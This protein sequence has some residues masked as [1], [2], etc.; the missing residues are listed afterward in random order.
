MPIRSVAP[1]GRSRVLVSRARSAAG[2]LPVVLE[3]DLDRGLLEDPPAGAM[4]A[5]R[6]W[7]SPR[8][9]S[10]VDGLRAASGDSE[11][12]GLIV[13]VGAH[14]PGFAVVQ[15]LRNAVA[16]FAASGRPTVCFAESFGELSQS[17]AGYLLA[18]ACDTIFLQP[19]G[20]VAIGG[21]SASAVYLRDALDRLGVQ[22]EMDRRHEFKSAA[23]TFVSRDM[24]EPNR[25]MLAQVVSSLADH[26]LGAVGAGRGLDPAAVARAVA[27]SPVPA[28]R[29]LEFGLVDRLGYA[30]D[31]YADVRDRAGCASTRFVERHHQRGTAPR[32]L[33]SRTVAVVPVTGAIVAGSGVPGRGRNQAT[34]GSVTAALRAARS[35]RAAAV[36]LRVNSPGGSY[37][38]SDAIRHQVHRLRADG[39]PVVAAMGSVAASGG[40]FVSM[41]ADEIVAAPGSVTG[42]IGVLGGKGVVRDLLAKGGVVA[43]TLGSH[44]HADMMSPLRGFSDEEWDKLQAFLDAVY[45]DFTAKAAEDRDM[46]VA[47]LE[48]HARGRVWTGV[49]AVKLGLVDRLGDLRDAVR[50]AA[51]LAG[52]DP[53]HVRTKGYPHQGLLAKVR[54]PEN[55]DRSASSVLLPTTPA[56]L[57]Q[58]VTSTLGV[59]PA[60][61]LQLPGHWHLS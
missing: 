51:R 11:V 60:G 9:Q 15:A 32:R 24:T 50:L 33:T 27:E 61:V 45:A 6:A 10:V 13:R 29:A 43:R 38:A 7:G 55:S 30:D 56:G 41:G 42:S 48:R 53:D 46:D 21:V 1:G 52:E 12:R 17:M 26:S 47:E 34:S 16:D 59:T 23:D 5:V 28:M 44:P 2:R 20:A 54:P 22:P 31:A 37:I 40:Y 8:L 49:D 58:A 57:L 36:V 4:S 14:S 39:I 3:I 18:T 35:E 25:E 19:S